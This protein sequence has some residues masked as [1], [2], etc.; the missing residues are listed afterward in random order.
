M[1]GDLFG[2]GPFLPADAAEPE[3]SKE[4]AKTTVKEPAKTVAVAK[5]GARKGCKQTEPAEDARSKRYKS[6]CTLSGL[7]AVFEAAAVPHQR[8]IA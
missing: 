8:A 5:G 1:Q 3:A 2:G 4:L 7:I 6:D